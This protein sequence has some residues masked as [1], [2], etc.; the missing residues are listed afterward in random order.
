MQQTPAQRVTGR[1]PQMTMLAIERR[2]RIDATTTYSQSGALL[3]ELL[4]TYSGNDLAIALSSEEFGCV[5]WLVSTRGDV[6]PELAL[7]D[8]PHEPGCV[9]AHWTHNE[10]GVRI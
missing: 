2:V 3:D 4:N 1:N 8:Y 10:C 9:G 6:A 5:A 7:S